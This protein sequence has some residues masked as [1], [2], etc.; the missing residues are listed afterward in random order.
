MDHRRYGKRWTHQTR[1]RLVE[2]TPP[3]LVSNLVIDTDRRTYLLDCVPLKKP[4]WPR[5]PSNIRRIGSCVPPSECERQAATPIMT[6][7]DI[8][9]CRFRYAIEG[10]N[11]PWRPVPHSMTDP[12]SISRCPWH[13]QR[14]STALFVVGPKAT[15]KSSI[16]GCG[17][18][19]TS[20]T[21]CSLRQ[22]CGSA[23]NISRPSASAAPTRRARSV[24]SQNPTFDQDMILDQDGSPRC[25]YAPSAHAS[26]ELSHRAL[27][28]SAAV[29]L[30]AIF[31][32]AI[33]ALQNNRSHS[34]APAELYTTD[35]RNVADGLEV[36]PDRSC[37]IAQTS[38]HHSDP[39]EAK[40]CKRLSI[41]IFQ[42]LARMPALPQPC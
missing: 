33:W 12:K 25:S 17:R 13:R 41:E 36:C 15:N 37:G 7:V 22:S 21:A 24:R 4:T 39:A 1:P 9:R 30:L 8:S 32:A 19:T 14:R 40:K 34:T 11:P 26:A 35:H 31:G 28:G 16:I 18:A 27:A 10:D 38:Q 2:P 29:G 20:S 3:E 5:Y 6:G 42:S 23:V